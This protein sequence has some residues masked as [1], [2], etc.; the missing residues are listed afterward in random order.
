MTNEN[1]GRPGLGLRIYRV[2]LFLALLVFVFIVARWYILDDLSSAIDSEDRARDD[3]LALF[4]S[5]LPAIL[6]MLGSYI[7]RGKLF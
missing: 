4:G 2:A 5:L 1:S 7:R 3:F 6:L